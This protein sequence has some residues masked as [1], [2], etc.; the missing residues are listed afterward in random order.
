MAR[1]QT[2]FPNLL[3]PS[4]PYVDDLLVY[5]EGVIEQFDAAVINTIL[6]DNM[7]VGNMDRTLSGECLLCLNCAVHTCTLSLT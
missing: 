5:Q 2:G 3:A 4:L 6:K 1:I 7:F